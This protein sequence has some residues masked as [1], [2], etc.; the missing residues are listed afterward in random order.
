MQNL[1]EMGVN[2]HEAWR[3]SEFYY[4]CVFHFAYSYAP[5]MFDIDLVSK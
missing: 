4:I 2:S 3:K 1:L 5:L